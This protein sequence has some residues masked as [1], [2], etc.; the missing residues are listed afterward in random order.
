VIDTIC[1]LPELLYVFDDTAYPFLYY[2]PETEFEPDTIIFLEVSI[3]MSMH[4]IISYSRCHADL[5]RLQLN[6]GLVL[7]NVMWHTYISF[8]IYLFIVKKVGDRSSLFV[9]DENLCHNYHLCVCALFSTH[10]HSSSVR[11]AR[12]L[13]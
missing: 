8:V 9:L 4:T 1:C 2:R 10:S 13:C 7:V 3:V 12:E 6:A 5:S 11:L